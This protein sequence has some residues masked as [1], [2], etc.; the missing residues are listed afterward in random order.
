MTP[1]GLRGMV[2]DELADSALF[3]LRF[4]QN[5]ARA[6]M[7]PRGAAGK[8]APLWLQ[9]L[10]GRDLLQVARQ[11]ADFPIVI[12]TFRECLNDHLDLPRLEELIANIHSGAV[13]VRVARLDVPSPF[14]ANLLFG[15]TAANMYNYDGVQPESGKASER[16]D[17]ALLDQLL[18]PEEI[19]VALDPRAVQQVDRRLRGVGAPPRSSVEMAEWLRRVGDVAASELEGKMAEFLRE[20]TQEE[21]VVTVR[22]PGTHEPDRWIL[23]EEKPLYAEAFE[24][25]GETSRQAATT[26]LLRFLATHALVGLRDILDRYPFDRAWA[27]QQIQAWAKS[28]RL[29]AVP[30]AQ[31]TESL[32]WSAADHFAQMQRG[33]LSLLRREVVACPPQQFADFLLRWQKRHPA[34]Q[35]EAKVALADVLEQMQGLALPWDAWETVLFPSRLPTYQLAWLDDLLATGHW[36]W[37]GAGKDQRHLERVRFYRR[38]MVG[39][40]AAPGA[41]TGE[42]AIPATAV[43]DLLRQRGALFT[44]EIAALAEMTPSAA[45]QSLWDLLRLGLVSND[46]FD[47]ARRGEP[48]RDDEDVRFRSR[49][50]MVAFLRNAS[51]RSDA[52]VPEGR[53]SALPWGQPDA[54]TAAVVQAWLLLNRYGVVARE[55][56]LM[57][58]GMPAWRVLYE[59]LSRMELA[60]EVRRGYFVEGLSGAQF[61][62]P[63]AAQM[64]QESQLAST[65]Q[66]PAILLPSLDP[67]NL[68]GSGAPFDVP[69]LGDADRS[70]LRRAGHWLVIHAGRPVLLIEQQGRRLTAPAGAAP[71]VL[72]LA[73]ACL[74]EILKATKGDIRHK[75]TVETWNEQPVTTTV[76]REWLEQAGFVRDYQSMTLYSV[77]S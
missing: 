56:A 27:E 18:N 24:G 69:M 8:R 48:Q 73:V 37:V 42:A 23:T 7:M 60:G 17:Q 66:A 16:L 75:L 51:R 44:P 11:H 34:H 20:L 31:A 13:Q 53:W 2:L 76:G 9:R 35:A 71:D 36:I 38:D 58:E 5:A 43:L 61:A 67:A 14:A 3:A 46:R 55:L 30:P 32:Q 54:E 50:E 49:R 21:R 62:L 64:L 22:L 70:F 77:W 52:V 4:R 26:I 72:R 59:V 57:E 63:D 15:F 10:R 40:I 12:E 39:Q 33:T 68:Y 6:L 1:E 65:A 25:D 47:V 29:V 45:R 41:T 19:G 74:P 28:G